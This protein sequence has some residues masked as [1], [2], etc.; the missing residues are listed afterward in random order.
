MGVG[1]AVGVGDAVGI[2]VAAGVG[3]GDGVGVDSGV[4]V[5]A[6]AAAGVGVATSPPSSEPLQAASSNAATRAARPTR[7]VRRA[8]KEICRT[9]CGVS[10]TRHLHEPPRLAETTR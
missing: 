9:G 4:A 7:T 6:A 10:V 1:V 5:G 2:G 3:S 8:T